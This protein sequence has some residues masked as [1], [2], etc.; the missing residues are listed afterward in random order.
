MFFCKLV[1][2]EYL[3]LRYGFSAILGGRAVV[4]TSDGRCG[5][6]GGMQLLVLKCKCASRL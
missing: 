6:L 5:V 2:W 3:L 4:A 1:W